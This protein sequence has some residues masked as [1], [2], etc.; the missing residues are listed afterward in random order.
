MLLKFIHYFYFY[1]YLFALLQ[2]FTTHLHTNEKQQ[3]KK[4]TRVQEF[5]AVANISSCWVYS[6][7]RRGI[8]Q[9]GF[10]SFSPIFVLFPMKVARENLRPLALS[11]SPEMGRELQK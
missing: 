11:D 6:I 2:H 10:S 7:S 9:L 8:F 4:G 1:M 3:N 5:R